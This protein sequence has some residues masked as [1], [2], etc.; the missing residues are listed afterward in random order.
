[1]EIYTKVVFEKIYNKVVIP[2]LSLKD[3]KRV[4][5]WIFRER[6]RNGENKNK[7]KI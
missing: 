7:I 2:N 3:Q 5:M 1:L 6:K 4:G